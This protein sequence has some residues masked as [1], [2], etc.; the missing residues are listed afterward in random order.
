MKTITAVLAV[1][2]AAV[3]V[4]ATA[5]ETIG[6]NFTAPTGG[7]SVGQ[8]S[9]IVKLRVTGTGFSAGTSPN[10]AFY[11]VNSQTLNTGYYALGFGTSP[12]AGFTPSNNIQNFLVGAVPAFSPTSTYTFLVNTGAALPSTLYFGVTDGVYTDNGGRFSIT[13][14]AVP[15]PASWAL[16]IGGFGLTGA[17]MRRRRQTTVAA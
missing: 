15:E 10:D 13:I 2:L 12:L 3:T 17:A 11:D 7:Q 1:A 14:N 4:P 8:Y 6:V 5:A 16:L 9:G